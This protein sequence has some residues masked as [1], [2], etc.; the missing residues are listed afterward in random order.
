V[1]PNL[2]N[3]YVSTWTLTIQRAIT[4]D[5]SLEVAYVGN[6]GTKFLGFTNINQPP[7]GTG[8]GDPL[9]GTGTG[10][11]AV[12]SAAYVCLNDF[13]NGPYGNCAP[14]GAAEQAAKPFNRKLPYLGQIDRL[15]NLDHSNYNGLHVTLTQRPSHGLSFLAGYT[16]SH[17]LDD[18]SA[19]FNANQLPPDSSHPTA[20]YGSSDFDIRHRLTFSTTYAL[21]GRKSP[22]QILER[23]QLNSVVTLQTGAPWT[24]QD[25]SND[26]S[27]TDQ[28]NELNTFGQL[29]DFI[30]NPSDF[31]SGPN[32]APFF[33][34][35]TNAACLAQAVKMDGGAA[36]GL[37]QASL[38]NNGCF[39]KGS[40]ILLPPAFGTLGTAGRNIFRDSGFKNWD[41]SVIKDMKFKE[42]LTAQFRAE[43][44]NVL[45]HPN[46]TDPNGPAG[47]GFNDPSGGAGFGCG[48]NTPDQASP[49]PVLG[50]GANRSIQL[51]LKLI[52]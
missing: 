36:I 3:P 33:S 14:D 50:T 40:S 26:F 48:C 42:R 31:K 29:W 22:G 23:W 15:S 44:F 49:N 39:A 38:A 52:W 2:R 37:A 9:A 35:A 28:V 32:P 30:G 12:G 25:T 17:G 46:F 4:N 5:M 24:A 51:G 34:G 47:A 43:F 20:V 27:G 10:S 6:H 18:A 8:W 1:D 45:N 16:Y 21:P 41:V 19:N 11:A 13:S 7:L